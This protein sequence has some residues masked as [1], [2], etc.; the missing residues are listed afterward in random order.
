MQ[1]ETRVCLTKHKTMALFRFGCNS[2]GSFCIIDRLDDMKKAEL[3]RYS[4]DTMSLDTERHTQTEPDAT[5]L[6]LRWPSLESE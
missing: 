1:S 2:P 5:V 6:S 4:M 3:L